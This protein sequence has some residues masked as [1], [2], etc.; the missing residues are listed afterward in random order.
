MNKFTRWPVIDKPQNAEIIGI[1][2]HQIGEHSIRTVIWQC[3]GCGAK[4]ATEAY[5]RDKPSTPIQCSG[6]HNTFV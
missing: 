6:C 5:G 2:G 3:Q 1:V 4:T